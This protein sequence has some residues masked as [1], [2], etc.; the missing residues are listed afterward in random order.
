MGFR[1]SVEK[2]RRLPLT[3]KL[4]LKVPNYPSSRFCQRR[5]VELLQ[6]GNLQGIACHCSTNP[7]RRLRKS[8]KSINDVDLGQPRLQDAQF[9]MACDAIRLRHGP[10]DRFFVFPQAQAMYEVSR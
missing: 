4:S 2:I 6:F 1:A 7:G 8:T 10:K 9:A 3:A 5:S